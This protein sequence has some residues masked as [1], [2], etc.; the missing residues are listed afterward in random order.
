L[1]QDTLVVTVSSDEVKALE[2]DDDVDYIENDEFR[3]A[4]RVLEPSKGTQDH[5][6]LSQSIPYGIDMVQASQVWD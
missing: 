4:T 1:E 5:R 3:Y 6:P 2:R